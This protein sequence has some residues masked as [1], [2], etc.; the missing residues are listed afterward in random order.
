MSDDRDGASGDS[1]S[2]HG[3]E[4]W[5]PLGAGLIWLIAGFDHGGVGLLLALPPGV[6]LL[7]AG[8]AELLW[9]G[10]RRILQFAALGGAAGVLLAVLELLF[11]GFSAGVVLAAVSAAAFIAA[12]RASLRSMPGTTGVPEARHSLMLA[13]KVAV[14]EALLSTMTFTNTMPTPDV[15]KRI[16]GEIDDALGFFR[17]RGWLEKPEGYHR[18]PLPLDAP[19]IERARS[20]G[21][22]FEHLSFESEYEPYAEEPGRDRWL[23]YTANRTAHAWVLRHAGPPRPWLVCIH[24]YQMGSPLVDL[25]AFDPRTYHQKLGLNLLLPVLPLHGKRKIGRRSGDGFLSGNAL[26][27]VHAEAQAMWDIRRLLSWARGQGAPAVGVFGLSLGGYNTALLASLD[28]DLVCAI[29]GIPATDLGRL[30]FEH[31]QPAEQRALE[32]AGLTQE[33]VGDV[34][35]VVS[36]LALEPKV[37]PEGRAIFAGVVDRLVSPDQVR[38]LHTHWGA[39]PIAWYQGGH[40]TF[41]RDLAV[42]ACIR[43]TLAGT[44]LTTAS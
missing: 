19:R 36:P 38:D 27:T 33:L 11:I 41:S 4:G 32:G 23:G 26:D 6:V 31:S 39:P 30:L 18:N 5:V 40:M 8:A 25:G 20:Q 28:D 1:S 3:A 14:D 34:L 44:G 17:E 42:K 21:I 22:E 2:G 35:R 29:P 10:D 43:S 13:A 12:G 16:R 37:A 9:G 7:A 15:A 24:G